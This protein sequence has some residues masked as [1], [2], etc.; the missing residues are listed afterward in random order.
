MY[1]FTIGNVVKVIGHPEFEAKVNLEIDQA[2][3]KGVLYE[4]LNV[5]TIVEGV[6][7]LVMPEGKLIKMSKEA[8]GYVAQQIMAKGHIMKH[9]AIEKMK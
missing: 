6:F 8:A 3:D 1:E 2:I 5:N 9:R 7:G 4:D